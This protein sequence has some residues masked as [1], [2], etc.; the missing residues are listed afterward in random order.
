[1]KGTGGGEQFARLIT[2]IRAD[3]VWPVV[4]EL[5]AYS[6]WL[7]IPLN[8]YTF[9]TDTDE[10]SSYPNS[11]KEDQICSRIYTQELFTFSFVFQQLGI[12]CLVTC[13]NGISLKGSTIS[14]RPHTRSGTCKNYREII[15]TYCFGVD[16]K[17]SEKFY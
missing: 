10:N 6:P 17:N 3:Q 16:V 11:I 9:L 15:I 5:F 1:M 2:S 7:W 14:L 4:L 12:L 8:K 13:G